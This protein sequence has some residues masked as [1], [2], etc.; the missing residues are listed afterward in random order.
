M[1][2]IANADPKELVPILKQVRQSP[3]S[4]VQLSNQDLQANPSKS[5]VKGL[6]IAKYEEKLLSKANIIS[7]S[8][9]RLWSE[10]PLNGFLL[11]AY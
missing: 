1:G 4:V 2:A 5:R 3:F 8:A 10:F 7:A 6:D 11:H 9:N